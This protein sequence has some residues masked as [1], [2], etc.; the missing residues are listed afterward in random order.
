MTE[1]CPGLESNKSLQ[2][3][4]VKCPKCGNKNE[5]FSDE[6]NKKHKCSSCGTELKIDKA[7]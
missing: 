6:L 1:H 7:A 3:V 5:I 2:A 4:E